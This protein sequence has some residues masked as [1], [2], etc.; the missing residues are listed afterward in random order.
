MV[1]RRLSVLVTSHWCGLKIAA[2]FRTSG[3]HY[4]QAWELGAAHAQ[5][6]QC[7]SADGD[8]DAGDG[9]V[10]MQKRRSKGEGEVDLAAPGAGQSLWLMPENGRR[11]LFLHH[12]DINSHQF[13][14]LASTSSSYY[15]TEPID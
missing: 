13:D 14:S 2:G 3:S 11:L 5:V 6:A 7:R 9:K 1:E 15:T 12:H 10:L 8:E 4:R